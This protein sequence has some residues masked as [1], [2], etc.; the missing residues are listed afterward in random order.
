MGIYVIV[1]C[2]VG[3]QYK[4]PEEKITIYINIFKS[5]LNFR[6]KW[7]VAKYGDPYSEFV[8]CI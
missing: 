4:S 2:I 5:F 6:G 1:Q 7:C 8:L 3:I